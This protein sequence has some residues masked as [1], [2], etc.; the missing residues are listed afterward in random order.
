MRVASSLD[1]LTL[2]EKKNGGFGAP[3]LIASGLVAF[4]A[5][6]ERLNVLAMFSRTKINE[7]QQR[8]VFVNFC[9]VFIT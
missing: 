4:S 1:A 8:V 2:S 5:F 9:S 6:L 3:F 7:R